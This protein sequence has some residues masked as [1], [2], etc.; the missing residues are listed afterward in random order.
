MQAATNG[1]LCCECGLPMVVLR[2]PAMD[3]SEHTPLC[4]CLDDLSPRVLTWHAACLL[5][6]FMAAA[7]IACLAFSG[8]DVIAAAPVTGAALHG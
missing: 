2:C 5:L 1:L 7:G 4:E 6:L 8:L 3:T